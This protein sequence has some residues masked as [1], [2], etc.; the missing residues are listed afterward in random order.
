MKNIIYPLRSLDVIFEDSDMFPGPCLTINDSIRYFSIAVT[1]N[2]TDL[3][4]SLDTIFGDPDMFVSPEDPGG[5]AFPTK[6]NFT[7]QAISFG[8]DTIQLQVGLVSV[9][10]IQNCCLLL[11][12]SL[13]TRRLFLR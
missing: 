12:C 2:G 11:P 10:T 3:L 9:M 8:S 4:I 1:E 6:A 7:W 5:H 13:W